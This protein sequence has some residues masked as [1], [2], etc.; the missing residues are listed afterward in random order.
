M[1]SSSENV[2]GSSAGAFEVIKVLGGKALGVV[3][4]GRG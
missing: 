4:L 1:V 3:S 2:E